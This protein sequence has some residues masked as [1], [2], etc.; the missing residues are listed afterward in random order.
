[1][2]SGGWLADDLA[3]A[4]AA[5]PGSPE[6]DH[7]LGLLRRASR[8]RLE[9]AVA[10]AAAETL[11]DA[12]DTIERNLGRVS[13]LG[14]EALWLEY[15][16]ADRRAAFQGAAPAAPGDGPAEVGC[17]LAADPGQPSHVAAFVAWRAPGGAVHHSYAVLHWD[18]EALAAAAAGGPP[19]EAQERMMALAVASVPPGFATEMEIWQ[20]VSP[21]VGGDFQRALRHTE[22]Q[23][24][25]E[26]LFLL[27]ALLV[28]DSD[29]AEMH[30]TPGGPDAGT[31][32]P[33]SWEARRAA[34][35][36]RW[37]WDRARPGLS[38]PRFGGPLRWEPSGRG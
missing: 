38:A 33:P 4:L 29:A 8:I 1:M 22:R 3:A 13:L 2:T 15:P 21:A 5:V 24:L 12:P 14:A 17:L 23:A 18:L 11:R 27:C 28:L 30:E 16:H 35:A 25:G 34:P 19:G 31:A 20:G 26:H 9:G 6:R 10:R 32:P 37:P 7:V 36:R